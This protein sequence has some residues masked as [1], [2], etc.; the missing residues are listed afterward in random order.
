MAFLRNL[1]ADR[2][3]REGDSVQVTSGPR[4]GMIGVVVGFMLEGARPV[5]VQYDRRAGLLRETFAA[6]EVE[7]STYT[8]APESLEPLP[9]MSRVLMELKRGRWVS[10]EGWAEVQ[11]SSG[12]WALIP[13]TPT[14]QFLR[15][16]ES[17]TH[18][19]DE[20]L[21]LLR[22]CML[23]RLPHLVRFL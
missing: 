7:I 2:E 23:T 17:K 20:V 6:N 18:Q 22:R 15:I 9:E 5:V 21:D 11:C 3:L 12:S 10:K 16:C 14:S 1:A 13:P 4:K 19:D 8:K